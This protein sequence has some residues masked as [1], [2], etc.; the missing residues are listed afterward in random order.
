[1]G[2]SVA[3]VVLPYVLKCDYETGSTEARAHKGC[4]AT[5]VDDDDDDGDTDGGMEI[6][7]VLISSNLA[8]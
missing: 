1:M 5:D 4:R 6:N 7:V 3:P 2:W 8:I